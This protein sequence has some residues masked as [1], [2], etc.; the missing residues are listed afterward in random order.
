MNKELRLFPQINNSRN[1]NPR[2]F[3]QTCNLYGF[4]GR[5]IPNEIFWI[6]LIHR[7]EIRHIH[8]KNRSLTYI[9]PGA[10]CLLQNS[11]NIAH[12]H[13]CL[14]SCGGRNK[15][16]CG[17]VDCDLSAHKKKIAGALSLAIWTDRSWSIGGINGLFHAT[18]VAF[19]RRPL[20]LCNCT[21]AFLD[22]PC[23]DLNSL[24]Q[25]FECIADRT[26]HTES[27]ISVSCGIGLCYYLKNAIP[28]LIP[29]LALLIAQP[30]F[31]IIRHRSLND[32]GCFSSR[33]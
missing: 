6:H 10:T 1:F 5:E 31:S 17:R 26:S 33:G 29:N 7:R 19:Q 15:L 25:R 9:T 20:I 22:M 2:I 12:D 16:L 13:F 24:N 8:Q 30:I 23:E 28:Y 4:S 3:G 11:F 21:W 32:Y 27:Q 14:L 18:N